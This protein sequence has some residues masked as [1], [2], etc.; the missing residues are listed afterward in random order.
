[1]TNVYLCK[2]ERERERKKY[3]LG[4]G[5]TP[6]AGTIEKKQQRSTVVTSHSMHS[7]QYNIPLILSLIYLVCPSALLLYSI[8]EDSNLFLFFYRC[9]YIQSYTLYNLDCSSTNYCWILNFSVSKGQVQLVYFCLY[10]KELAGVFFLF[11][12]PEIWTFSCLV[13]HK[14]VANVDSSKCATMFVLFSFCN[15][16]FKN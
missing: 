2:R 3:R 9:T 6:M 7:M 13:S 4:D 1:M 12:N 14:N 16:I 15:M 11:L 10:K 8:E 5:L